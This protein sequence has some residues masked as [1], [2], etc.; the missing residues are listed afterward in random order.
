[1]YQ[2]GTVS[3]CILL[4]FYIQSISLASEPDSRAIANDLVTVWKEPLQGEICELT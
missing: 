1:M 4:P 3:Q 2:P